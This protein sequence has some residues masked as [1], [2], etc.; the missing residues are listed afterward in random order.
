[1]RSTNGNI[2][3]RGNTGSAQIKQ[4]LL[5]CIQKIRGVANIDMSDLHDDETLR[6]NIG[7]ILPEGVSMNVQ[8]GV[9]ALV[10]HSADGNKMIVQRVRAI[11]G[12]RKVT[13]SCDG[14]GGYR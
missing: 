12:I 3:V 6:L 4:V 14:I 9:V 1:M 5:D 10:S 7:A 8:F 2:K 11:D 13:M